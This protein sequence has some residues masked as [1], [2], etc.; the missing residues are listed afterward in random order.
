MKLAQFLSLISS[1]WIAAYQSGGG[2]SSVSLR[3]G[4]PEV[5]ASVSNHNA[6]CGFAGTPPIGVPLCPLF[7]APREIR[8]YCN[9]ESSTRIRSIATGGFTVS[10][11]ATKVKISR[12]VIIPVYAYGESVGPSEAWDP[13]SPI[14]IFVPAFTWFT[15]P[16][17]VPA[18]MTFAMNFWI[19]ESD[20]QPITTAKIVEL[21]YDMW[22]NSGQLTIMT[23]DPS[24][25]AKTLPV[26]DKTFA[27]PAEI[28][29]PTLRSPVYIETKDYAEEGPISLLSVGNVDGFL[30][31]DSS[32]ASEVLKAL[33]RTRGGLF[34]PNPSLP[35]T[36]MGLS[37]SG[38]IYR[39]NPPVPFDPGVVS[40]NISLGMALATGGSFQLQDDDTL[41]F[42]Y[43]YSQ[44]VDTNI[45]ALGG[46]AHNAL[47]Y[48]PVSPGD[49]M[50]EFSIFCLGESG[51]VDGCPPGTLEVRPVVPYLGRPDIGADVDPYT[52][53][54]ILSIP[55]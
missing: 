17:P 3:Y 41:I 29:F 38:D 11:L 8:P 15:L 42:P 5:F 10:R 36:V 26:L 50:G 23:N 51:I 16:V 27:P 32:D 6:V 55:R 46:A 13:R 48:G 34:S 54:P 9:L 25:V 49:T 31:T 2:P 53:S 30:H 43:S 28:L 44:Y 52:N 19:V 21:G 22:S 33:I 20:D 35:S 39:F 12:P 37:K 24:F 18:S 40:S 7:F 45:E 14:G 4:L 47:I 1:G